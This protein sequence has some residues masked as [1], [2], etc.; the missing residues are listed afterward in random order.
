MRIFTP[1]PT[2]IL[3]LGYFITSAHAQLTT[4]PPSERDALEIISAHERIKA[5]L[6]KVIRITP[7]QQQDKDGFIEG[8]VTRVTVF[9]PRS[10]GRPTRTIKNYLLYHT[11]EYGW[12]IESIKQDTRGVYLEISSQKKGRIYV[13]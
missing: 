9:A 7:G 2:V 11:D 13:R 5:S 10:A 4:E 1:L 6:Y 3:L 8:N 12:F